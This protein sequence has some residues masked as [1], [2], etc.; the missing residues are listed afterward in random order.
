M[1][2]APREEPARIR[3][4]DGQGQ[5]RGLGGAAEGNAAAFGGMRAG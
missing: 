1:H 2:R 4:R 3:E 5:A